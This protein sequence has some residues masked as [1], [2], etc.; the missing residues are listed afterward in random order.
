MFPIRLQ[1]DQR[2]LDFLIKFFG[3]SKISSESSGNSDIPDETFFRIL[4][5][6][7]LTIRERADNPHNI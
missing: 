4:F 3:D 2:T 6:S 1:I 7:T 5:E